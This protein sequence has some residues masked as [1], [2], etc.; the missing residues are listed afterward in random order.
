MRIFTAASLVV[1]AVN[2]NVV[3]PMVPV[4]GLTLIAAGS[5]LVTAMLVP[6]AKFISPTVN[7]QVC[8]VCVNCTL[9]VDGTTYIAHIYE[10]VGQG[11]G[12]TIGPGLGQRRTAVDLHPLVGVEV[13]I[14]EGEQMMHELASATPPPSALLIHGATLASKASSGVRGVNAIGAV[15]LQPLP[16]PTSVLS[17]HA[18]FLFVPEVSI[19]A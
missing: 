2:V 14:G 15:G 11:V 10:V 12:V 6:F 3:A 13:A 19:S 5:L 4:A 9:G 16:S 1:P 8:P 7:D 18:R 17:A